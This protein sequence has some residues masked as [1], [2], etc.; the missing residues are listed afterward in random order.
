MRLKDDY[1]Q[2]RD[3][4]SLRYFGFEPGWSG[5]SWF[6]TDKDGQMWQAITDFNDGLLHFRRYYAGKGTSGGRPMMQAEFLKTFKVI[7]D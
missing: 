7:H 6:G 5:S 2:E 4:P 3:S 1:M